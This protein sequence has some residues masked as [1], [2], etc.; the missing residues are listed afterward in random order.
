MTAVE[1]GAQGVPLA[2]GDFQIDSL[3][4]RALAFDRVINTDVVFQ[5]VR[6][7]DVFSY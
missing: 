2:R 5:R 6:A 7:S 1:I 4:L 3:L